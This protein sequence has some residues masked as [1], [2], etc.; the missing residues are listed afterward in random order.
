MVLSACG[1]TLYERSKFGKHSAKE[2][3][4]CC[5]QRF[6]YRLWAGATIKP[7]T[8]PTLTPPPSDIIVDDNYRIAEMISYEQRDNVDEDLLTGTGH[9]ASMSSSWRANGSK[10]AHSDDGWSLHIRW[11]F[12]YRPVS[13]F[14]DLDVRDNNVNTECGVCSAIIMAAV[15]AL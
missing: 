12:I 10:L 13:T 4:G 8:T 7:Y 11:D 3:E 2:G 15:P 14:S 5:V 9:H 1:C 6:L